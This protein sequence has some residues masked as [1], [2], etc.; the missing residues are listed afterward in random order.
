M[1]LA[2]PFTFIVN[3][4]LLS[5]HNLKE[6]NNVGKLGTK[7]NRLLFCRKLQ[8]VMRLFWLF[9]DGFDWLKF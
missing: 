8:I 1:L 3:I 5:V 6:L 7:L 9:L 2:N 4:Q